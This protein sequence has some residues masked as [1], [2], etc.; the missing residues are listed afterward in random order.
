MVLVF[1]TSWQCVYNA[2]G[3]ATRVAALE[4]RDGLNFVRDV[5][6]HVNCSTHYHV[7]CLKVCVD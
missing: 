1:D 3:T 5:V 4:S 7:D 6:E 2:Y